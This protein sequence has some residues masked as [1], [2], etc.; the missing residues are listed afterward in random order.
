MDDRE[1]RVGLNEALFRAVNAQVGEIADEARLETVEIVCEC[2]DRAC[3]ERISMTPDEYV[4]LRESSGYFAIL[5]GHDTPTTEQVIDRRSDYVIVQ[6]RRGGPRR[7]A[8]ET[9]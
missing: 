6:K 9:T 3:T 5:P 8:N 2:G 1:R 4:A 7:L